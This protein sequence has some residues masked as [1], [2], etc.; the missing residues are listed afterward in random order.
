MIDLLL[1][2]D[3]IQDQRLS[4]E[5]YADLVAKTLREGYSQTIFVREFTPSLPGWTK[6][7][8]GLR[9]ARYGLYPL[10][11]VNQKASL[12]HI[13]EHGYAHLI[14][15]LNP[16]K[17]VVTVHDLMPLVRWKGKINGVPHGR[18]PLLALI[19]LNSLKQAAHLIAVSNNTRDDLVNLLG[20]DPQRITVIYSGIDPVFKPFSSAEKKSTSE[21]TFK[22]DPNIKKILISGSAFYKNN[23]TACKTAAYLKTIYPDKFKVIKTGKPSSEWAEWVDQYHLEEDVVD[24]GIVSRPQM[25]AVYNAV[26]VLLFPSLYEGFGW[27]PLEAMACGTPVVTSNAASIPEVVGDAA[28]TLDPYDHIGYAQTISRTFSDQNFRQSYIEKGLTRAKVFTWEKTARQIMDVY[29]KV[30]GNGSIHSE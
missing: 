12:Y 2:R 17:T 22:S 26:D 16:K 13:I 7:L 28:I 25:A 9:L 29:V 8:G 3:F 18:I 27:P 5:I 6:K 4:M 11:V 24:V 10:Q 14:P 15:W 30:I 19:S 1:L 21:T 20:C 23:E